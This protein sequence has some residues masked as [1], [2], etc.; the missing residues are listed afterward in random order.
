MSV[1]HD[2]NAAHAEYSASGASRW[3]HCLGSINLSK[4][5]PPSFDNEWSADGKI[6]H[7]LLAKMFEAREEDANAYIGTAIHYEGEGRVLNAGVVKPDMARAVQICLDFVYTLIEGHDDA[8]VWIEQRVEVPSVVVSGRMWGTADIIVYLPRTRQLYV[9]DYKHGVGIFVDEVDNMQLGFYGVG[10]LFKLCLPV[11]EIY[12]VI[13]QPRAFSEG[14]PVRGHDMPVPVENLVKLWGFLETQ[15]AA[16]LDP[17]A[18]FKPD[19]KLCRWCPAATICKSYE[20]YS[21]AGTGVS[22]IDAL[23]GNLL[24]APKNMPIEQLVLA[25]QARPFLSG[26]LKTQYETAMGLARHGY[27]VPGFKMVAGTASRAWFGNPVEIATTLSLLTGLPYD[28]FHPRQLIT[29][30]EAEAIVVS[31]FRNNTA[32]ADG[33]TK[34]AHKVRADH[35]S[36]MAREAMAQLTL[37]EPRG[38]ASLVPLSDPRPRI[39]TAA[40]NFAGMV[41]LPEGTAT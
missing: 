20:E 29:L 33:E 40:S 17:Y 23:A 6:A 16:T 39:E 9:I 3:T 18:P 5:A 12:T 41:K 22:S 24:P 34:K 32:R 19:A 28:T 30:T 21:L 37:K 2:N 15:A 35:A 27:D 31:A 13:V 25:L 7:A 36:K 4:K 14:G 1:S 38:Y 10:A 8:I 26:W 11:D